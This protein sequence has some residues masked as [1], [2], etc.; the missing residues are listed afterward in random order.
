MGSNSEL[1]G[2]NGNFT[3]PIVKMPTICE[4]LP[5]LFDTVRA[6]V[7]CRRIEFSNFAHCLHQLLDL[8]FS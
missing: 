6:T 3:L 4:K 2:T 8:V 7:K 5:K 1:A